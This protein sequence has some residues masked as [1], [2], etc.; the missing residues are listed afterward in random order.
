MDSRRERG[1]KLV[2]VLLAS[3]GIAQLVV[4]EPLAPAQQIAA[5]V[6]SGQHKGFESF[7]K[8]RSLA[9]PPPFDRCSET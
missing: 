4:A 1:Q 8:G 5:E 2:A 6:E 9:T 3:M 7:I